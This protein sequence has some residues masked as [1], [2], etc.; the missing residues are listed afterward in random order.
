MKTP[1]FKQLL[2][3]LTLGLAHG[4][5]DA[6]AGFLLGRSALADY[7]TA[8]MILLMYNL[9]A[10]GGMPI[11]GL[12]SDHFKR[13][14][15]ITLIGLAATFAGFGLMN[16][17]PA[18]AVAL[19]AFGSACF[20]AGAGS[21]SI[22]STP[23][24]ASGPGLFAA[25]GVL[26]LAIGGQQGVLNGSLVFPY[27][28]GIATVFILIS[29]QAAPAWTQPEQKDDSLLKAA[30]VAAVLLVL[31]I[32]LRS[33]VW[34]AS[35]YALVGL[36]QKALLAAVAAMIGKL[37]GG[38]IADRVGWRNYLIGALALAVIL[39]SLGQN[40]FALTLAAI[41]FLQSTTP[42]SIAALAR[43]LP[44]RPGLAASLALG[45]AIILGGIPAMLGLSNLILAPLG[46]VIILALAAGMYWFAFRN[47][48]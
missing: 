20:H 41:L 6:S 19:A 24:S 4:F 5:S 26:G 2:L 47:M 36:S 39:M 23:G 48:K 12:L 9:A 27:P 45:T 11:A 8:L 1:H 34:T 14:K 43:A 37:I 42:A 40:L 13:P 16:I 33:S 21:M 38:F 15:W 7:D 44:E 28:L 25:F 30:E 46:T 18:G 32:A 35:Q 17:S 10:F 3:P 31:A 29:L 22:T